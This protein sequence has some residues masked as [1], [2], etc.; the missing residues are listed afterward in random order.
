MNEIIHKLMNPFPH[1]IIENM[2]NN[3]ELEL[4]WEELKFLTKPGKLQS[5]D[6][7]GASYDDRLKKYHTNSKALDL[8]SLYSIRNIS[9]ILSVNRKLFNY[10]KTY[11]K[12]SPH[13]VK[14]LRK[15]YDITKLRYYHNDEYYSPHADIGYDTIACTYFYKQPKKFIG[16]ELFF[17][18]YNY[19]ISCKNNSCIIFPAYFL[20]GVNNIKIL[21]ND[22]YSGFGRY[23]MTQF[24]NVIFK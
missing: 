19:E 8:D 1:L 18:E 11:S 21:D 17:P 16:G 7:Y 3:G 22:Y 5:P 12:L 23:C 2:Y 13:Y 9:N 20:H 6:N 4:I 15:N 10:D 14:F 24:T